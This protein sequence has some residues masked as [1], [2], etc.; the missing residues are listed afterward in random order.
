MFGIWGRNGLLFSND[1]ISSLT[2]PHSG[3][4]EPDWS[5]VTCTVISVLFLYIFSV[6]RRAPEPCSVSGASEEDWN[7]PIL[8]Q[9][10]A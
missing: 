3:L 10:V 5:Q 9:A 7:K 1:R 8:V 2:S 4:R 6:L